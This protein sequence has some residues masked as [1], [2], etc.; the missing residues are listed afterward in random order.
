MMRLSKTLLFNFFFFFMDFFVVEMK[1][2]KW[3]LG[4]GSVEF[5][6]FWKEKILASVLP[7]THSFST[8]LDPNTKQRFQIVQEVMWIIR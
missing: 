6:R 2:A 4:R 5:V 3:V 8:S 7:A 1:D